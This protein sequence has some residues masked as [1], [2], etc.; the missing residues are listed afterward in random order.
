MDTAITS[1]R[2]AARANVNKTHEKTMEY[3]RIAARVADMNTL[4]KVLH[5]DKK[6]GPRE[7]NLVFKRNNPTEKHTSALRRA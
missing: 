7:G 1:K 5:R 4:D 6:F 2:G 3:L